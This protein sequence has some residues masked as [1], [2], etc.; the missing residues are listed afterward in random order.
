[1]WICTAGTLPTGQVRFERIGINDVEEA[2]GT[3][4]AGDVLRSVVEI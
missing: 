1:M 2:F 3:M 4:K